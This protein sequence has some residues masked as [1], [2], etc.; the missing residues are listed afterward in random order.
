[1]QV[2]EASKLKPL[3]FNLKRLEDFSQA[4]VLEFDDMKKRSDEMR[5]T[6]GIYLLIPIS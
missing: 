1:M 2:A 6:N 4:I 5:N 3:E